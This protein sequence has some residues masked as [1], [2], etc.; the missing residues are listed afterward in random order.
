MWL[1]FFSQDFHFAVNLFAALV[2]LAIGWLHFDAWTSHHARKELLKW[3]GFGVLALSFLVQSTLIEQSVLGTALLGNV[4]EGLIVGLR[5]VGY[6]C[7]IVGHVIDP[8]QEV[9]KNMGLDLEEIAAR[10]KASTSAP[11]PVTAQEPKTN[12]STNKM[13]LLPT[14]GLATKWVVPFGGFVVAGLYWRRAT[15][16]LERHFKRIAY[17]FVLVALSDLI[18]LASLLRNTDN[19]VIYSWVAAFGWVWMVGQVLLLA[20]LLI[21]GIWVWSYLT[22]RFFSQLFMVFITT[23]VIVFFVV[24]VSITALLLRNIRSDSLTNLNTAASVLNYAIEA[25]QAE[26]MAGAQQ[27]ATTSDIVQAVKAKDHAKLVSLTQNY[28]SD[29]KQ[30]SL[31]ITDQS[32][33]VLVRG[34]DS[35]KWGGSVSSDSL[36]R[37]ALLADSESSVSAYQGV[38]ATLQVRS[39]VPI[40]DA[41]TVVGSIVTGLELNSSF[42][43]GIKQATGLQSSIY[44]GD[45]LAATTLVSA[46]GKT[47]SVGVKFTNT[48]VT[49]R[50]LTD[51]RPYSG[52]LSLQNKEMLGVFYPLKDVDNT[53]PGMLLVSEPQS[54]ILRTAGQSIELTFLL[55]AASLIISVVPIYYVTKAIEKQLD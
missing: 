49:K 44:S 48:S 30:S 34:E 40:K 27:M 9:P 18:G 21:M 11:A 31:V 45:T 13:M 55:T 10:D 38:N 14:L 19:P 22:K 25:K 3:L 47:R 1:Q 43:D 51:G 26:T 35:E 8:L 6:L 32:G 17:G 41:G 53:V 16:G 33:K 36:V 50:V 28:L 12:S 4:T 42:V 52:A 23:T 46:D 2:F 7:V 54:N 29:K 5:L 37:R 15:T 24:T 20:G 39:A